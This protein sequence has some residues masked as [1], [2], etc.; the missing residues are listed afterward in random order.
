MKIS[1]QRLVQIIREE[2]DNVTEGLSDLLN[3]PVFLDPESPLRQGQHQDDPEELLATHKAEL[4]IAR[5]QEEIAS[6]EDIIMEKR[7]Q[8]K[9]LQMNI[10]S[11][12]KTQHDID[13]RGANE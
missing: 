9:N 13:H 11:G 10:A 2:L 3:A 12:K 7:E 6:L 4:S 8:I 5:L 1:I